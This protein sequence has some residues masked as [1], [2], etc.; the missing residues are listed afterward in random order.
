MYSDNVIPELPKTAHNYNQDSPATAWLTSERPATL[1]LFQ[2]HLLSYVHEYNVSRNKI[3]F[4]KVTFCMFFYNLFLLTIFD[5]SL[6]SI[7]WMKLHSPVSFTTM[8]LK[9]TENGRS[10]VRCAFP[11]WPACLFTS[12]LLGIK[13]SD[14][15]STCT[16]TLYTHTVHSI[17]S[18]VCR[19][20]SLGNYDY[21]WVF[22][23]F[24]SICMRRVEVSFFLRSSSPQ[25]KRWYHD[26]S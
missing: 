16:Y 5:I 18:P 8:F 13:F 3:T 25:E 26:Y 4:V 11:H 24:F 6:R 1:Y 12:A 2:K 22:L 7:T 21:G 20:F 15:D 10:C 19:A 17:C 23:I 14:E 9:R